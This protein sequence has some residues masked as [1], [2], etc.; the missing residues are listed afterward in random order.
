LKKGKER[1]QKQKMPAVNIAGDY[2]I[3]CDRGECPGEKSQWTSA[4]FLTCG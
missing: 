4:I 1:L 3:S 2:N